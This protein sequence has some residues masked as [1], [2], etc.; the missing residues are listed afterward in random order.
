MKT[1]AS[2]TISRTTVLPESEAWATGD[3]SGGV[4]ICATTPDPDASPAA[5]STA[6]STAPST[7]SPGVAPVA[8]AVATVPATETV[9]SVG[10][11]SSAPSPPP[12]AFVNITKATT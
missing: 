10:A 7:A 9:A 11:A 3:G 5:D 8:V 6:P 12:P 4:G 2:G 1:A